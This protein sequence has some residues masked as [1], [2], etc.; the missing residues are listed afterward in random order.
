LFDLD[1][2]GRI[3]LVAQ[4]TS[5]NPARFVLGINND[6][7]MGF[8]VNG[9]VTNATAV[10]PFNKWVHL[11]WQRD[12]ASMSLW[13]DG[14]PVIDQAIVGAGAALE[15]ANTTLGYF[16]FGPEYWNGYFADL[17]MSDIPRYTEGQPI[18]VPTAPLPI[19]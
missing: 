16:D 5:A 9:I 12:S 2:S 6:A 4:H 11:V 10:F 7:I 3:P 17:R 19:A 15:Q 13:Q 8:F 18:E 1:P 14:E